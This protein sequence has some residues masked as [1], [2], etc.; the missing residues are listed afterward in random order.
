M[1]PLTLSTDEALQKV[2]K[3]HDL[4]DGRFAVE[5]LYDV[6]GIV[7]NAERIRNAQPEG[8]K[9]D[10][11]WVASIPMPIYHAMLAEWRRLGFGYPERQAAI[12]AWVNDPN[13]AKFR[14]KRGKV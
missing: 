12:K 10:E 4:N 9:K 11:Y 1:K 14:T 2:V 3:F 6:Q 8:W 13:N 7:D 5:T